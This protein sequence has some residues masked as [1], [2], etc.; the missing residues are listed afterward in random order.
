[1]VS[2]MLSLCAQKLGC[3]GGLL[4]LLASKHPIYT[5]LNLTKKDL[6]FNQA[7][8]HLLSLLS[9][10]APPIRTLI[11]TLLEVTLIGFRRNMLP[12]MGL[13]SQ[14]SLF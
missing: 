8:F 2:K 10:N 3:I 7:K 5:F 11:P 9:L 6:R 14:N 13:S 12:R 1:M 4:Y